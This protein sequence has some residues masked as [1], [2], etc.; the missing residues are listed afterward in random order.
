MTSV[1]DSPFSL[2]EY[3]DIGNYY[4]DYLNVL[5]N[6]Y[7]HYLNTIYPRLNKNKKIL[8]MPFLK[9]FIEGVPFLQLVTDPTDPTKP[10]VNF[11]NYNIS[12]TPDDYES[13]QYTLENEAKASQNEIKDREI[14]AKI[15][16][17]NKSEEEENPVKPVKKSLIQKAT[18]MFFK[19][20]PK[21]LDKEAAANAKSAISVFD[22]G[23]TPPTPTSG[24]KLNPFASKSQPQ[25]TLSPYEI[26]PGLYRYPSAVGFFDSLH[27]FK[28][29]FCDTETDKK[30]KAKYGY[31]KFMFTYLLYG[32]YPELNRTNFSLLDFQAKYS[33]LKAYTRPISTDGLEN[34]FAIGNMYD[35]V[36]N[37]PSLYQRIEHYRT[38][39]TI[40]KD[41]QDSTYGD[42]QIVIN[43][44]L[45][46]LKNSKG[47][48]VVEN[49]N[50]KKPDKMK[51]IST[52][53]DDEDNRQDNRA[54]K[55]LDIYD[56]LSFF[57]DEYKDKNFDNKIKLCID[58]QS[59][60]YKIMR[61]NKTKNRFCLLYTAE[62]I[63]DSA[64]KPKAE[65]IDEI[66]GYQ[67]WY[68][69][70]LNN[71]NDLDENKVLRNPLDPRGHYGG[72]DPGP[73]VK[74][75]ITVYYNNIQ[76]SKPNDLQNA[77]YTVDLIYYYG[78]D[79]SNPVFSDDIV[80]GDTPITMNAK[81]TT[82]ESV[83]LRVNT[84]VEEFKQKYN[85]P[86]AIIKGVKSI[87]DSIKKLT[88]KSKLDEREKFYKDFN[89]DILNN[90]SLNGLSST[91][92]FNLYIKYA[93]FYAIKRL[94]DTLQAEV[95]RQY[96][97]Q[98]M[99]FYRVT[100]N[101]GNKKKCKYAVNFTKPIRSTKGAV[102]VTHDRMLFAYAVINNIPVILDLEN[103]MIIFRPKTEQYPQ[104]I[105]VVPNDI[106][107][108]SNN[109][110]KQPWVDPEILQNFINKTQQ[111]N[112]NAF[113]ENF[114]ESKDF[115]YIT[116]NTYGSSTGTYGGN[117]IIQKGGNNIEI[118]TQAIF[119]NID[120]FMRYLYF[121]P[122]LG[123]PKVKINIT[124]WENY[125]TKNISKFLENIS[126][127]L[128]NENSSDINDYRTKLHIKYITNYKFNVLLIG[129]LVNI[130]NMTAIIDVD[131]KEQQNRLTIDINNES[132]EL[133]VNQFIMIYLNDE[134]RLYITHNFLKYNKGNE[135]IIELDFM[136]KGEHT[137]TF[138][139]KGPGFINR[140]PIE[141]NHIPN[142]GDMHSGHQFNKWNIQNSLKRIDIEI[143]DSNLETLRIIKNSGANYLQNFNN[144]V[145]DKKEETKKMIEQREEKR[146]ENLSN[147]IERAKERAK[148]EK[149]K[150][151]EQI[152]KGG[153]LNND[154][155]PSYSDI[156]GAEFEALNDPKFLLQN[157]ITVLTYL[158][159]LLR[160]YELSF[161]ND[162][163]GI[164][165]FYCKIDES[166]Q[167]S[168]TIG[169]HNFMPR[170]I[171]FYVFLTLLIDEY[172]T[173]TITTINF[174]L[175]EYYLYMTK[176]ENDI[177][178]GYLTIKSY[179]LKQSYQVSMTEEI[180]AELQK[181]AETYNFF[182]SIMEKVT[183]TSYI[184]T[185]IIYLDIQTKNTDYKVT[186]DNVDEYNL[187]LRGFSDLQEKFTTK[188][189]EIIGQLIDSPL[190]AEFVEKAKAQ[191]T[192]KEADKVDEVDE[193]GDE[194]MPTNEETK[195]SDKEVVKVVPYEET[196]T[197]DNKVLVSQ[198]DET[199]SDNVKQVVPTSDDKVLVSKYD[200]N[201][202]ENIGR[203]LIATSTNPL[204]D[205]KF[206]DASAAAGG[207]KHK[208][209]KHKYRKEKNK[210]KR[211][212]TKRQQTKIKVN[213]TKKNRKIKK[214]RN[215]KR[216][217]E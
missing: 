150:A 182:Q 114:V 170:D 33:Y 23:Y 72:P 187:K 102:L 107:L 198:Y 96:I 20:T 31:S 138:G 193:E 39:N 127:L 89:K 14:L 25:S 65:N 158:H 83:M 180:K 44:K 195:T 142:S 94:G 21:E 188:T 62:T 132:D 46:Y 71:E 67:N 200:E 19:K 213:Q 147:F 4:N 214:K 32:G 174:A 190:I 141:K 184:I 155:E 217:K 157:N 204:R 108:S 130:N 12:E 194:E 92:I 215:T 112:D 123:S 208:L 90:I 37:E 43:T 59:N 185:E 49:I 45:N 29:E 22:L 136:Y 85:F 135:E 126:K 181:N 143:F 26:P 139:A 74:G 84:F 82:K 38:N 58:C 129:T 50:A 3:N 120:P 52:I 69:E 146:K 27:D 199:D 61:K 169:L 93:L 57:F 137:R 97:L 80:N 16:A 191:Q 73:S 201:E 11:S 161:I 100:K 153:A 125:G 99:L 121:R 88:N 211:K 34:Y 149:A 5:N 192:I 160:D 145:N 1:K 119:S 203:G 77:D 75:N 86:Q 105:E 70:A 166:V 179:L 103:H 56:Y 178:Y 189:L 110:D 206:D 173:E 109:E 168:H 68:I 17:L 202:E 186:Y 18:S 172:N 87:V 165:T 28:L 76:Y 209:S 177:Y 144:T 152:K 140:T 167:L 79:L 78:N 111:K 210:T 91:N 15:R 156:L 183:D 48:F 60:L 115:E 51:I 55:Q 64:S 6:Y 35:V 124:S 163:E 159:Q 66:F 148:A 196:K 117:P 40:L 95:C 133:M 162:E 106:S 24:N 9:E 36:R 175:F 116:K 134:N 8:F 154:D 216:N 2:K 212:R 7:P 197:D 98:A 63:T 10:P 54:Q 128:Y 207:K 164:D 205:P 176:E 47:N 41:L 42:L 101:M 81:Q 118:L 104:E 122:N 171:E 113:I 131:A 13:A 53:T 151:K 30:K